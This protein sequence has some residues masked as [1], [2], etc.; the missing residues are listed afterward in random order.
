MKTIKK[1]PGGI[2]KTAEIPVDT[3]TVPEVTEDIQEA[4]TDEIPE[5]EV[6]EQVVSSEEEAEMETVSQE[7]VERAEP[8][9]VPQM[10][11]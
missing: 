6:N 1:S 4:E 9:Q 10:V 8:D 3:E 2:I 5:T 7:V 11:R